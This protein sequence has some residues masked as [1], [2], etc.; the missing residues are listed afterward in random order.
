MMAVTFFRL[1]SSVV[2]AILDTH[3]QY[4]VFKVVV[5]MTRLINSIVRR[6][7]SLFKSN[8]ETFVLMP[9]QAT[10]HM[11]CL[12][13]LQ[14]DDIHDLWQQAASCYQPLTITP[15]IFFYCYPLCMFSSRSVKHLWC[16]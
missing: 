1:V 7:M 15:V 16:T 4:T 10:Y 14:L 5:I 8:G 2:Y 13:P 6:S 12:S 9:S 11:Y 3:R